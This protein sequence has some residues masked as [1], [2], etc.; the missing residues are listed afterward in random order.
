MTLWLVQYEDQGRDCDGTYPLTP[1]YVLA[2]DEDEAWNRTD[3]QFDTSEGCAVI[4]PYDARP[5][6]EQEATNWLEAVKAEAWDEGLIAG[7]KATNLMRQLPPNPA[8][9]T[10]AENPYRTLAGHGTSEPSEAGSGFCLAC[11][12]ECTTS[13]HDTPEPTTTKEN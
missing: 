2:P 4:G 11:G 8:W 13:A 5:A 3:E 9:L 7:G 6:T 12:F 10:V 1:R